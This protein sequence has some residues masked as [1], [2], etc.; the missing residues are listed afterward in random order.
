MKNYKCKQK[1]NIPKKFNSTKNWKFGNFQKKKENSEK[2]K[3]KCKKSDIRKE[4]KSTILEIR[5]ISENTEKI[6]WRKNRKFEQF[7]KIQKTKTPD[8]FL[9]QM[10]TKSNI[11]IKFKST[12]KLKI[13][14]ISKKIRFGKF[15]KH[16][17]QSNIRKEIKSTKLDIR[18]IRKKLKIRII[19]K[20][21]KTK[22][23]RFGNFSKMSKKNFH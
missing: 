5:K 18:K 4:F 11:P 16:E 7:A 12:K 10:K 9:N 17:K 22:N 14:E 6:N 2:F 21:Y 15:S 8:N 23:C 13:R 1:S 3:K 19:F 20:K